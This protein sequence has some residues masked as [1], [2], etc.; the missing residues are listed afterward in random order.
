MSATS[1]LMTRSDSGPLKRLTEH[2]KIIS[3]VS[4]SILGHDWVQEKNSLSKPKQSEN[5]CSKQNRQ[6]PR[7]RVYGSMQ[8]GPSV[9][10]GNE[11]PKWVQNGQNDGEMGAQI[12]LDHSTVQMSLDTFGIVLRSIPSGNT[13]HT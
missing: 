10:T 11:R 13:R 7:Q 6:S 9:A 3:I 8:P 12:G 4:P 1:T 5:S 2:S